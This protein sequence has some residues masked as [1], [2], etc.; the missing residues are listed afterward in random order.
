[1]KKVS[2]SKVDN[3]HQLFFLMKAA[4]DDLKKFFRLFQ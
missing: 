3:K 1:L 4:K 2:D